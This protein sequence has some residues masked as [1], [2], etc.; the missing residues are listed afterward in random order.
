MSDHQLL[1]E[2]PFLKLREIVGDRKSNPPIAA[3]I[4]VSRATFMAGCKIGI[5]PP[6]VKI[7][8]R[9]NAWRRAD[10]LELI[11]SLKSDL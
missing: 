2:K 9:L 11:K 3:L 4:P 6:P 7:S 5:Y 10:I 8:S 1:P